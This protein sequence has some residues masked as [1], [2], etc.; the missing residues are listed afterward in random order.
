[1]GNGIDLT[2]ITDREKGLSNIIVKLFPEV[3]HRFCVRHMYTKF[4]NTI[5]LLVHFV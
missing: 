4:F 5:M 3:E 2:M 1:M